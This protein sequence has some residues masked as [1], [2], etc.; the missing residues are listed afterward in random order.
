MVYRIIQPPLAYEQ[1]WG[2]ISFIPLPSD[3]VLKS[4]PSTRL[5]DYLIILTKPAEQVVATPF[6][7]AQIKTSGRIRIIKLTILTALFTSSNWG[8]AFK[9]ANTNQ[10]S[11]WFYMLLICSYSSIKVMW[12]KCIGKVSKRSPVSN[13]EHVE[14]YLYL[15]LVLGWSDKHNI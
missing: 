1:G 13:G 6:L 12:Y 5:Q 9:Q 11:V 2:Q 10:I 8:H 15:Y 7:K 4:I 14:L 3:K